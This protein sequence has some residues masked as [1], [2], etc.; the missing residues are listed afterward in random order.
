M[1][2]RFVKKFLTI[3][4]TSGIKVSF[5][6]VRDLI[7]HLQYFIHSIFQNLRSKLQFSE[8][9]FLQMVIIFF[10]FVMGNLKYSKNA[11][12]FSVDLSVRNRLAICK[13]II[14]GLVSSL[15]KLQLL[16]SFVIDLALNFI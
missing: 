16:L 9:T 5:F 8:L 3:I 6:R 7:L 1:L 4:K 15:L 10:C 11:F 2:C 12:A 13:H 14:L